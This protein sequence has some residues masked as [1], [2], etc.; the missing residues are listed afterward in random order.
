MIRR[1]WTHRDLV[2]SLVRIQFKLRYRQSF[3]GWFWAVLPPLATLGVAILVFHNVAGVDSGKTSYAIFTMAAVIPWTFFANSLTLGAPAIGGAQQAVTRL[4]FP[5]AALPLSMVGLSLLDLVVS[6]LIFLVFALVSGVGLPA[7]ALWFPILVLILIIFTSGIV[8]LTSALNVFARDVR[9]A[10]PLLVQLWL[11]I[12]PVMYPLSVV[13]RWLR[14]WYLA[15][16]MTGLVE[17]FRQTLVFGHAP[18]LQ[19]LVLALLGAVGA[20]LVGW[21]Y[22]GATESRFA[23]MI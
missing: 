23:D 5:R 22:F 15:N 9:L 4:P 3:V 16:P 19:L 20:F 12:T 14:P 13:P 17:S 6:A 21:W 11:F 18:S 10:V 7:A 1:L 2:V 8:L